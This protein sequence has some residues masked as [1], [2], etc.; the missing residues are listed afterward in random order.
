MLVFALI[1]LVNVSKNK[2]WMQFALYIKY[3]AK[4]KMMFI[5]RAF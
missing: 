5:W 2:D 4:W 3:L 1:L